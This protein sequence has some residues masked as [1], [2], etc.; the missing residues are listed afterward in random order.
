VTEQAA[1]QRHATIARMETT[2]AIKAGCATCEEYFYS[3]E[4][5]ADVFAPRHTPRCGAHYAH[6]T[7][8]HCF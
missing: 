2:G 7:C 4:R 8:D 1:D 5:P 3:A 6:C